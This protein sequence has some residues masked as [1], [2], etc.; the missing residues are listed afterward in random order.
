MESISYGDPGDE[1]PTKI[2]VSIHMPISLR[3]GNAEVLNALV[4]ATRSKKHNAFNILP[5]LQKGS[6]RKVLKELCP[7]EKKRCFKFAT[8][9]ACV[10]WGD[11]HRR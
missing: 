7:K 4:I 8:H 9:F 1:R 6:K 10:T 2:H 5:R 3:E 11:L